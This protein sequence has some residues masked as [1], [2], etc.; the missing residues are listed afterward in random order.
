VDAINEYNRTGNK[1]HLKR[2][3]DAG[4]AC[5]EEWKYV[6]ENEEPWCMP[7]TK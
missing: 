2:C 5:V 4:C 1:I 7:L 3:V 6:L